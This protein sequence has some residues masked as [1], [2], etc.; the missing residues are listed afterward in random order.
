MNDNM[1]RM[2]VAVKEQDA[3]PY[4]W[5]DEAG[6]HIV[7]VETLAV[8]II[9]E[10]GVITDLN[11]AAENTF[12]Y[13][14]YELQ[15]RHFAMLTPEHVQ[16]FIQ[17]WLDHD[18]NKDNSDTLFPSIKFIGLNKDGDNIPLELSTELYRAYGRSEML[19]MFHDLY[20]FET[21]KDNQ[22]TFSN[23]KS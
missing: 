13:N 20:A 2:E 9:S 4:Y 6:Q 5:A 8:I 23:S 12:G 10:D 11:N 22:R 14:L 18:L 3:Y 15:G 7:N 1:I 19:L 21:D 16:Q 17:K